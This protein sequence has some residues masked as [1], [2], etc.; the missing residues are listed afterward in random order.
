MGWRGRGQSCCLSSPPPFQISQVVDAAAFLTKHG[1]D[2]APPDV[3]V[4]A[5]PLKVVISSSFPTH[6]RV[7]DVTR[8]CIAV[9]AMLD[10]VTVAL[11]D[12]ALSRH[13]VPHLVPPPPPPALY[14]AVPPPGGEQRRPAIGDLKHRADQSVQVTSRGALRPSAGKL[15]HTAVPPPR[16]HP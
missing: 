1:F 6:I 10:K 12:P 2:R 16:H 7:R 14:A 4:L 5:A 13:V 15:V 3:S 11:R 9:C 8:R